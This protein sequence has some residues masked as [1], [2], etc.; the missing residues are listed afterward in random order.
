M[1]HRFNDMQKSTVQVQVQVSFPHILHCMSH[2]S[3]LSLEMP[4]RQTKDRAS[5]TVNAAICIPGHIWLFLY[6]K[7][8]L[9]KVFPPKN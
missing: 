1:Q 6:D 5:A 4:A 9:K 3:H 8:D 2:D 7:L